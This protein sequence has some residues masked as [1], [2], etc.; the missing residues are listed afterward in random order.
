MLLQAIYDIIGNAIAFFF[1]QFLAKSAHQFARAHKRMCD[2]ETQHVP[3]STHGALRT[4]SE[5]LSSYGVEYQRS[6][7][8]VE[9]QTIFF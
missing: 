7:P 1:G 9:A 5:R 6:K 3:T 2:S 4:Y 8:L